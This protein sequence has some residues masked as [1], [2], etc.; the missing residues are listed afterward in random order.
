[1]L[2]WCVQEGE[3]M[4][5]RVAGDP[6]GN[7]CQ[8]SRTATQHKAFIGVCVAQQTGD[9]RDRRELWLWG[10]RGTGLTG[11]P[12]RAGVFSSVPAGNVTAMKETGLRFHQNLGRSWVRPRKAH[13]AIGHPHNGMLAGMFQW[14]PSFL[15]HCGRQ[16]G[17]APS[18]TCCLLA[19]RCS[20]RQSPSS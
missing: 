7:A 9:C 3:E 10:I 5:E 6:W 14:S 11:G 12:C 20:G 16:Q 17:L 4:Q 15:S 2:L 1:M 8:Q 18:P 13:A 19:G